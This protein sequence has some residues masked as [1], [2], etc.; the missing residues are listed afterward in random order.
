MPLM[1]V[2]G[3][4]KNNLEWAV[5]SRGLLDVLDSFNDDKKKGGKKKDKNKGSQPSSPAG[6]SKTAAVPTAAAAAPTFVGPGAA[7]Y[8]FVGVPVAGVAA[9]PALP[10]PG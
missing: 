5:N 8:P 6:S 2:N 1:P 7:A 10:R 3:S 9:V 4:G